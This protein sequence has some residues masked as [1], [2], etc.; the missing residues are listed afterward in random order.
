M[1]GGGDGG[2]EGRGGKDLDDKTRVYLVME[3]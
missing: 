2:G 3:L 1:R